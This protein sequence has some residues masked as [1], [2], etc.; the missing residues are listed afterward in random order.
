MSRYLLQRTIRSITI[1]EFCSTLQ[2]YPV[3]NMC[4]TEMFVLC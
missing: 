4:V 3:W 2:I 1:Y